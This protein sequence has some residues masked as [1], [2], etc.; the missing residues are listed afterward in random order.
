MIKMNWKFK[1]K[2]IILQIMIIMERVFNWINI[3][4]YFKIWK[5]SLIKANLQKLVKKFNNVH[6]E[7]KNNI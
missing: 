6:K 4:T 2:F 1:N 7:C 5:I 3:K